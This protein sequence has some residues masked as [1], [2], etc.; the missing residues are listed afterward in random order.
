MMLSMEAWM[1]PD[2]KSITDST[3]HAHLNSN[4]STAQGNALLNHLLYFFLN[5]MLTIFQGCK[6]I[7][8]NC[9]RLRNSF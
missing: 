8:N 9:L 5:I 2:S 4:Q 6:W 1:I 3:V 7:T